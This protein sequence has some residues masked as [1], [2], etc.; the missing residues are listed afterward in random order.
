MCGG[1]VPPVSCL[2]LKASGLTVKL[3]LTFLVLDSATLASVRSTSSKIIDWRQTRGN[4]VQMRHRRRD[5]GEARTRVGHLAGLSVVQG[6][7]SQFEVASLPALERVGLFHQVSLLQHR[8]QR[9]GKHRYVNRISS[10]RVKPSDPEQKVLALNS[11]VFVKS[12]IHQRQQ[13]HNLIFCLFDLMKLRFG[14]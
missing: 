7:A 6:S 11:S 5:G 8:L 12:L 10:T 2:Y 3:L 1:H 13:R 9:Q 4:K 14:L